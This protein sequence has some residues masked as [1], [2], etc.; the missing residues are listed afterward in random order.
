MPTRF[1]KWSSIGTFGR[2]A[3]TATL[4]STFGGT[5]R[6]IRERALEIINSPDAPAANKRNAK[7]SKT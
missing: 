5:I 2:S 3:T 6:Q 1:N 7:R 4:L